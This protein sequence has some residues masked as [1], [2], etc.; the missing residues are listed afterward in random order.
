MMA[1]L[2]AS[3]DVLSSVVVMALLAFGLLF[4]LLFAGFQLHCE[5][6]HLAKLGSNVL[7]AQPDWVGFA[8]NYTEDHLAQHDIDNYVEQAYQKGR[9]W[10]ADNIRSWVDPKDPERAEILETQVMQVSGILFV[11]RDVETDLYE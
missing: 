1:R 11:R 10:L 6:L 3:L 2:H 4:T 5:A 8:R 7:A 9:T